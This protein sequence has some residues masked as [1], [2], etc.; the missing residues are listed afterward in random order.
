MLTLK[1]KLRSCLSGC[2]CTHW[3]CWHHWRGW[4]KPVIIGFYIIVLGALLPLL[5]YRICNEKRDKRNTMWFVAG[6]FVLLT[7]P[8]FLVGLMQHIL[9][10]TQ[11]HLQKHII[12]YCHSYCQ[13]VL[14]NTAFSSA[15][16]FFASEYCGWFQYTL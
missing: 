14:T 6:L 7:I 11:P 4:F 15:I 3:T 16:Y 12:R 13:C 9:N 2:L 10:Y 5:L 8:V 1:H